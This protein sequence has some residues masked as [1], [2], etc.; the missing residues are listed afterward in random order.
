MAAKRCSTCNINF[1]AQG[2]ETCGGC[3]GR[4][5]LGRNLIPHRNWSKRALEVRLA[6]E[7]A[8]K[9]VSDVLELAVPVR[10]D[11]AGRYFISSH[12]VCRTGFQ[13]ELKP[14]TVVRIEKKLYEVIG[15]TSATREYWL[16]RVKKG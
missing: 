16:E 2:H 3:G 9:P 10:R 4:T 12:D 1:P 7:E 6:L 13:S 11:E 15:Y 8:E 14:D 5:T